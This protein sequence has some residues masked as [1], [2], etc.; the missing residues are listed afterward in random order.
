[1]SDVIAFSG[2]SGLALPTGLI[3]ALRQLDLARLRPSTREI[4]QV[5]VAALDGELPPALE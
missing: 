3:S 1:M 4:Y 2:A 5:L